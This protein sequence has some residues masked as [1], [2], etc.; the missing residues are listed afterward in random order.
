MINFFTVI[1]NS[2]SDTEIFGKIINRKTDKHKYLLVLWPKIFE[3]EILFS[4]DQT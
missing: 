1:F 3:L 2:S 4:I